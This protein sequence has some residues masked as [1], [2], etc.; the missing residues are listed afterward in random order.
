MYD[1]DYDTHSILLTNI[2]GA[3]PKLQASRDANDDVADEYLDQLGSNDFCADME[4]PAMAAA[5][6]AN[7]IQ[8]EGAHY[9]TLTVYD[10]GDTEPD[11]D[12]FEVDGDPAVAGSL[13]YYENSPWKAVIDEYD[14]DDDGLDC[15]VDSDDTEVD[16][17]GWVLSDGELE[18]KSV[19]NEKSV[20]GNFEGALD[21][22]SGDSSGDIKFGFTATYCE[23]G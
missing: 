12:T 19:E 18:I 11:E 4:E 6:A 3:C 14:P 23:L 1:S 10:R 9:L 16:T 2:A 13:V 15:G 8:F 20:M 17:D 21:D 22:Q 5:K 7:A